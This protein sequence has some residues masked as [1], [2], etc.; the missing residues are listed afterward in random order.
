MWYSNGQPG[1]TVGT[2]RIG[3]NGAPFGPNAFPG[4]PSDASDP[5]AE[6]SLT[7]TNVTD[8]NLG[9]GNHTFGLACNQTSGGIIFEQ[10]YVSVVVLGPG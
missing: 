1:R 8:P 4:E 9:A 10:T 3:V 6:Q 2:C 7:L 5:L